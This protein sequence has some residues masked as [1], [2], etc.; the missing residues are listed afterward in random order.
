MLL[1]SVSPIKLDTSALSKVL[2][3]WRNLSQLFCNSLLNL[4]NFFTSMTVVGFGHSNMASIVFGFTWMPSLDIPWP[5]N[6]TRSS[7]NF[8]IHISKTW[9][10]T[11][12]LSKSEVYSSSEMPSWIHST[13]NPQLPLPRSLINLRKTSSS[14][15]LD[16][17]KS[18]IRGIEY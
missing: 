17:T 12:A 8:R 13:S 1:A 14:L 16:Q 7:Q 10:T 18:S 4:E 6:A 9:R 5:K 2:L 3:S 11:D 15:K